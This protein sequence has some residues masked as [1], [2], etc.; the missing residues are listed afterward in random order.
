MGSRLFPAMA[1]NSHSCCFFPLVRHAL[2]PETDEVCSFSVSFLLLA[3][4]TC[5]IKFLRGA[6]P[7]VVLLVDISLL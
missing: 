6:P 5:G 1:G 7:R 3:C 4:G 2:C